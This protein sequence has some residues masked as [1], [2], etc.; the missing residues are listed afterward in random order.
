MLQAHPSVRAYQMMSHPLLTLREDDTLSAAERLF[1]DHGIGSA[2]VV[3]A[4]GRAV[5][6][7][8]K[9]DLIRHGRS[10]SERTGPGAISPLTLEE[11]PAA[12]GPRVAQ[13]PDREP[14]SA[15]MTPLFLTVLP[16]ATMAEVARLMVKHGV[17]HIFVRDEVSGQ[18]LGV[19]SSFDVVEEI[20]RLASEATGEEPG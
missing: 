19:V 14:V 3:N 8:T 18:L 1:L 13:P 6:V 10:W 9:T 16:E 15:W 7:L 17:H 5:G 20:D 12:G 4:E 2:S 11:H